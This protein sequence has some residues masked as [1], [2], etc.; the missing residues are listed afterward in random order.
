[1]LAN[2]L[3]YGDKIG[4]IA[5]SNPIT[6]DLK[7]IFYNG[8]N[9]IE[10]LGF[11]VEI[12]DNIFSN[13]MNYSATPQEKVDDL[14]DMFMNEDIRAIICAQ[15]GNTSN[16]CLSLID[17]DIIKGNPK[18]FTGI[19]DIS[20]LLNAIYKKTGLVTFHGNDVIWG[21]GK[22]PSNYDKEEFINRFVLS[23]KEI[24]PSNKK[25]EELLK[26][27]ASGKLVGGNLR[28]LLKLSGTEYFPDFKDSIL[29]IE[30]IT[31]EL[32]SLDS[33]LTQVEHIGIFEKIN[34]IIIGYI[35][36][37]DNNDKKP[38]N[39]EEILLKKIGDKNIPILKAP[40]FGH[41]CFN[42]VLPIGAEVNIDTSKN[43]IKIINKFLT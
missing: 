40:D 30:D 27:N 12:S 4:I 22:N 10:K 38:T 32:D 39:L 43:E 14:H 15:G 33:L 21:F 31:E 23:K 16:S 2:K 42:S 24:L 28:C 3:N 8:I 19:S 11:K 5:P 18:I 9:F 35:D 6:D 1:M 26:G 7:D 41:N 37:I 34:G 20:V 29:F 36:G 25:R 17:W 13:S